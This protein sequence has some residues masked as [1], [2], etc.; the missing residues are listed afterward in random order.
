MQLAHIAVVFIQILQIRTRILADNRIYLVLGSH[1]TGYQ[2]QDAEVIG[3]VF[4]EFRHDHLPPLR[5][6][7]T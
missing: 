4:S 7:C 1:S 3:I 6:E 5:E 2:L